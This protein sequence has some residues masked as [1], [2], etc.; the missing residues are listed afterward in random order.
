MF[1]RADE[2]GALRKTNT[3]QA[4]AQ[5]IT[6][7]IDDEPLA[8]HPLFGSCGWSTSKRAIMTPL[9]DSQGRNIVNEQ[10]GQLYTASGYNIGHY[11]EQAK[12][13]V[14]LSGRYLG[15]ILNGNRLMSL[16]SSPYLGTNFGSMGSTRHVGT[17]SAANAAV[18][19]AA[20]GFADVDP[21]R[22]R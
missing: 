12:V 9:F 13:F 22:L 15:E 21:A 16:L 10:G 8:T 4:P 14:D 17:W 20:A 5:Q 11:V 1:H 6:V 3:G 7:T 2:S 18:M 19:G